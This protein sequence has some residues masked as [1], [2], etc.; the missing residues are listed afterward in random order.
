[1]LLIIEWRFVATRRTF[2]MNYVWCFNH[3][4]SPKRSLSILSF[5]SSSVL[6]HVTTQK[7]YAVALMVPILSIIDIYA[8]YLHRSAL[9][10]STV[11][12]LLPPSFLGMGLG[13]LVDGYLTDGGARWDGWRSW[14]IGW[15][16]VIRLFSSVAAWTMWHIVLFAFELVMHFG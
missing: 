11:R 7:G 10:W 1:M 13:M 15:D 2:Q 12:I 9:H 14:S 3:Q 8:A 16:R 4:N 5:H 6:S